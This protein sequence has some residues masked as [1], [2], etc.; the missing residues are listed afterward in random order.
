MKNL[1]IL[2]SITAISSYINYVVLNKY[3]QLMAKHTWDAIVDIRENSN[4][5]RKNDIKNIFDNKNIYIGKIKNYYNS[6]NDISKIDKILVN[7][8]INKYIDSTNRRHSI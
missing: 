6:K 1:I 5:H 3:K 8:L 2:G 7:D 4:I